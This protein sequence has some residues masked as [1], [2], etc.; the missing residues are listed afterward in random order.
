MSLKILSD[1]Y[2]YTFE[3]I[4]LLR[5][6]KHI[7]N[8]SVVPT[9]RFDNYHRETD[10]HF[11]IEICNYE[12]VVKIYKL[13]ECEEEYTRTSFLKFFKTLSSDNL[14]AFYYKMLQYLDLFKCELIEVLNGDYYFDI[15]GYCRKM[16]YREKREKA[17]EMLKK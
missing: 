4:H 15:L 14:R 16:R 1:K 9:I 13:S 3:I 12:F 11:R 7:L 2:K 17:M 6:L 5:K 8:N 10:T